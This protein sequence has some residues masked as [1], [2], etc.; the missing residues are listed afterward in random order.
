[1]IDS[2]AESNWMS[3]KARKVARRRKFPLVIDNQ[4]EQNCRYWKGVKRMTKI[5]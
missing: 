4:T 5:D 3:P 2:N 1:M